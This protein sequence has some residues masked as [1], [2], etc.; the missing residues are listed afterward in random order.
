MQVEP[1]IGIVGP[2]GDGEAVAQADGS[3][4][5]VGPLLGAADQDGVV[6]LGAVVGR[7][8]ISAAEQDNLDEVGR[9]GAGVSLPPVGAHAGA[10]AGR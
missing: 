8:W 4:A 1:D 3:E 6:A 9:A 5:G 2:Q 7:H 10:R